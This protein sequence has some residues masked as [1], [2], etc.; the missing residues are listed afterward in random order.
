M[1]CLLC[2]CFC[3]FD[4]FSAQVWNDIIQNPAMKNAIVTELKNDPNEICITLEALQKKL[5]E[6]N[7]KNHRRQ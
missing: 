4:P 3:L 6:E 5:G 2:L 7:K 1:T